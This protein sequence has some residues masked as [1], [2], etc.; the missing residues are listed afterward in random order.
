MDARTQAELKSSLEGIV[1]SFQTLKSKSAGHDEDI[2]RIK[3]DLTELARKVGG[4]DF[5]FSGSRAGESLSRTITE[6]QNF[7]FFRESGQKHSGRIEVKSFFPEQKV[8]T[9]DSSA[10]SLVMPM[11]VS[12]I[13]VPGQ[14]RLTIRDLLRIV[15]TTSNS[16]EYTRE[17]SFTNNAAIV[18]DSSPSPTG[19][20]ENILK[21]E[22]NFTFSLESEKVETLAHFV[23]VS[24]QLLDDVN[25]LRAYLDGRMRY[26][27]KLVEEQE[28]LNGPGT[29]GHLNG[30]LAVAS[31]YDTTLNV[32]GD[33]AVDV[34]GNAIAQAEDES[35][36][37]VDGIVLN[38]LDW[39][40]VRQTKNSGEG[41]YVFVDPQG[42]TIAMLWGKPVVATKSM[43]KGHFLVG[44]FRMG[45]DLWDRE[46]ATVEISREHADNFTKNMATILCEERIA[47]TVT[48][49]QAFVTGL[50]P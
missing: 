34:L 23:Q 24:K 5:S 30:L 33:T 40:R 21:P 10:G 44:S 43:A 9:G 12:G 7:K 28:L 32:A 45:A 8:L 13:I 3:E 14:Q 29:N 11:R 18:F 2:V 49:P 6:H 38:N 46:Q 15:P 48:R 27:L 19:R 39:A 26:G 37:E 4:S 25:G 20:R 31:A 47:L 41:S 50:L 36:F 1:A 42:M 35:E 16:I 17:V 22:S